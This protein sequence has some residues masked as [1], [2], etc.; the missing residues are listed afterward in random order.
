MIY[1][2]LTAAF[3]GP[4]IALEQKLETPQLSQKEN[5]T[6]LAD[7][8]NLIGQASSES[9]SS[10]IENEQGKTNILLIGIPGEPWP[11]P[12]LTDSIEVVSF[13]QEGGILVIAVP[14][15]LLVKIPGSNYETRINALYSIGQGPKLLQQA[16]KEITGLETQYWFIIDLKTMEK[17]IDILGG[18]EVEVKEDIYDPL[19]PTE[20]RGYETFSLKAG[21]HHLDGKTAI[22]YIRSRHDIRGDFT[23]IERQQQVMEIIKNKILNLDIL[24]DFPKI[25]SLYNEFQGK[26]NIGLEEIKTITILAK[27]IMKNQNNPN[28]RYLVLDA[29]KEDSLLVSGKS[30]FGGRTAYV[31]WPKKGK[32]N[33]SEIKEEIR[34][35]IT[36][37]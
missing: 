7:N 33:Y 30:I 19:F 20:N 4:S 36:T 12:E 25:V 13:G 34:R 17:I 22:K 14:R 1:N 24:S 31:L 18:I 37:D 3:L 9:L 35:L 15:D 27:D 6:P 10:V 28:I 5:S 26:T 21:I 23:R 32:F 11:S 2:K 16:L 29:G 8:E